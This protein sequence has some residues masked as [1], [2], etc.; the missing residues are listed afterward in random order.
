M[1][2]IEE[3]NSSFVDDSDEETKSSPKSPIVADVNDDADGLDEN[4]TDLDSPRGSPITTSKPKEGL[5]ASINRNSSMV[6]SKTNHPPA[7][8]S[9]ISFNRSTSE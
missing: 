8:T 9:S 1:K 3:I 7:T 5:V 4:D 2:V 6:P